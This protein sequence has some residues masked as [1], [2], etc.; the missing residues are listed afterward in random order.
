MSETLMLQSR[1]LIVDDIL[2]NVMLLEDILENAGYENISSLTDPREVLAECEQYYPDLILLDIRMPHMSGFDVMEQ[3]TEKL[4]SNRPPIMVLTAQTDLQTKTLSMALG[5]IDFLNKPFDHKDAL[6]RVKQILLNSKFSDT[7]IAYDS[8]LKDLAPIIEQQQ[9]LD[10]KA[11]ENLSLTDP[12]TKLPNRRALQKWILEAFVSRCEVSSFYIQLEGIDQVARL[13][14]HQIADRAF[15]LVVD[16]LSQSM[17]GNKLQIGVWSGFNL[18]AIGGALSDQEARKT[19][20]RIHHLLSGP[21]ELNT[22]QF[23]VQALV[24]FCNC[25]GVLN[26]P[27]EVIR[28]AMIAVPML[29][30]KHRVQK[31]VCDMDAVITRRMLIESEIRE[32]IDRDELS[33]VYQPKVRLKD[34]TIIGA[35]A[36]VRWSNRRLGSVPPDEFIPI[37]ERSGLIN[38]IGD[39]VLKQAVNQVGEWKRSSQVAEDFVMAINLSPPQLMGG[40]IK[41][42]LSD[43]LVVNELKP[44]H[45]QLE[46]TETLLMENLVQ[47][48]FEIDEQRRM[49]VSVAMDDFGTGYSSLSYLQSLPLDVLKVDRSFVGNLHADEGSK[50]L[51]KAILGLAKAFNLEVVAEGIEN[52]QQAILLS[53]MGCEIGQGYF[54]SKP[55]SAKDFLSLTMPSY[56]M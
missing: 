27:D 52:V 15:K 11:L 17:L 23:H 25:Q 13:Y 21:Q 19:A 42:S 36:L 14:G 55:V 48:R 37:A 40:T 5:A 30:D 6:Q 54:F 28:R 4:G 33:V 7:P 20:E 49:G 12:L 50:S 31:Y 3:L 53:E 56:S 43:Q 38:L 26:Q 9:K 35:E 18:V 32:A 46:L 44:R 16:L 34:S 45:I 24:G 39:W 8:S 10:Q 29:Q 41:A 47:T 1:I 2:A 22:L 51:V